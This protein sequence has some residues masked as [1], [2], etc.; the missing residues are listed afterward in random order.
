MSDIKRWAH[1]ENETV[2]NVSLWDGETPWNPGCEV[3]EL[4]DDSPVG[5]GWTRQG[6]EFISPVNETIDE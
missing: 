6:N 5:P 2:T 4:P 1:I 3:V